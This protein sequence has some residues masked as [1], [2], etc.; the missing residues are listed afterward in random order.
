M[1]VPRL[2]VLP[3]FPGS[4]G[5][6]LRE[7][8]GGRVQSADNQTVRF[9]VSQ[10][11]KFLNF[12]ACDGWRDELPGVVHHGS[13]PVPRPKPDLAQTHSAQTITCTFPELD[14]PG[15]SSS[16]QL[17]TSRP[18]P[19]RACGP[20]GENQWPP[21]EGARGVSPCDPQ[22]VFPFSPANSART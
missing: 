11:S 8:T 21:A 10:R 14:W 2:P 3:A 22:P 18:R 4:R 15:G 1:P 19:D 13:S 12:D 7:R 17:D 5:G 20:G 16:E 6:G 9:P